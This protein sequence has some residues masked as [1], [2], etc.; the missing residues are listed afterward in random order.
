MKHNSSV[1]THIRSGDFGPSLL[2]CRAL[3]LNLRYLPEQLVSCCAKRLT[4]PTRLSNEGERLT[5]WQLWNS[6]GNGHLYGHMKP[7]G[8][9]AC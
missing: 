1:S 8:D 5:D 2:V 6:R 9:N 7:A 4:T 3:R